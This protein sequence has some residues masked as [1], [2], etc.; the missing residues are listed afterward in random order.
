MSV[1]KKC[2]QIKSGEYSSE[3]VQGRVR[4]TCGEAVLCF[5]TRVGVVLTESD[6]DGVL[7]FFVGLEVFGA[8]CLLES[9]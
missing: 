9:E 6:S 3:K 2:I 7:A 5:R 8:S 1:V 4:R